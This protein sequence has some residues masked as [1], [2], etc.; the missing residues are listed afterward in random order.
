MY[1]FVV[2]QSRLA[3][4]RK[5]FTVGAFYVMHRTFSTVGVNT[6]LVFTTRSTNW[7]YYKKLISLLCPEVVFLTYGRL[8]VHRTQR[9]SYN[10]S[11]YARRPYH[12][13]ANRSRIVRQ[14]KFRWYT[15]RTSCKIQDE[16]RHVLREDQDMM[17]R[18]SQVHPLVLQKRTSSIKM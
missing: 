16:H 6:E 8:C 14:S 5:R 13:R 12:R 7:C 3:L 1:L 2:R 10:C 11:G 15:K 18:C 17:E 9:P 4:L